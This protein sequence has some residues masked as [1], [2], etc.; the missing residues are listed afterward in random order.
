MLPHYR[1][2]IEQFNEVEEVDNDIFS[3][4]INYCIFSINSYLDVN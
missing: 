3:F 2:L 4:C 1:L